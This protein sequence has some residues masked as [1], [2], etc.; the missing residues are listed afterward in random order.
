MLTEEK[1]DRQIEPEKHDA[2]NAEDSPETQ[3]SGETPS[4]PARGEEEQPP[5]EKGRRGLVDILVAVVILLVTACTC[6][7]V[8]L[9]VLKNAPAAVLP[10]T[11]RLRPV[12]VIDSPSSGS[13]FQVGEE[14]SIISTITDREGI[15]RVELWVND[16]QQDV[17]P[18]PAPQGQKSLTVRHTWT[19]TTAGLYTL[20]MRAYNAAGRVNAPVF[21]TVEV[22]EISTPVA[23]APTSTAT[24]TR[25]PTPPKPPPPPHTTPPPV[26]PA[27]L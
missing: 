27:I 23:Q 19:P 7:V 20:E 14:V 15:V 8:A 18:D 11:T 16:V 12:V 21:V 22:V 24:A 6:L 25:P 9:V 5:A 10:H 26:W 13:S 4:Q 1:G 2:E 3:L 17:E